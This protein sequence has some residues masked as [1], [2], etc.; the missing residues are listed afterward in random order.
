MCGEGAK[1]ALAHVTPTAG[2][3]SKPSLGYLTQYWARDKD[4]FERFIDANHIVV[5][6][7]SEWDE[8]KAVLGESIL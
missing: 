1:A 2:V 7:K 8:K 3:V 6:K 4:A 5:L